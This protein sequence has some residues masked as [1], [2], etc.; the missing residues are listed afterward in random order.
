M[1]RILFALAAFLITSVAEAQQFTIVNK[2]PVR[3]VNRCESVKTI[4]TNYR[5]PVGSHTHTCPRCGTTWD[6]AS[7]PG[8]NCPN[9]GTA[10]Y[11]Q[12]RVPRMVAVRT[13]ATVATPA[14]APVARQQI[15]DV[16]QLFR[17]SGGCANGQCS[18]LQRR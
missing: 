9:C 10:Q 11:V 5:Q 8:H 16:M 15:Q 13:T 6:H 17:S 18:T 3:V 14:S 7:N 12:D 1:V 4:T 2:M